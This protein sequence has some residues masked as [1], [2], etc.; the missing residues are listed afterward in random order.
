MSDNIKK[1]TLLQLA[2]I[3]TVYKD[4]DPITR[5]VN[6]CSCGRLIHIDFPE[7]CFAYY[8]HFIE[9][10][11]KRNLILLP[12]NAHAQCVMCNMHTTEEVRKNYHNYMKYRYGDDIKNKL[13][14]YDKII[15]DSEWKDFYI[16]QLLKLSNKFPELISSVLV[17]EDTGELIESTDVIENSIEK[18]FNTYSKT[19]KEDLDRLCKIL[20]TKNIE[21]ERM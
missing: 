19:Y 6:C 2:A 14:N 11:I 20:D 10:S 5:T 15:S 7:D 13:M 9:R 21:W 12:E 3:Y 4:L 16:K 1:Y 17:N 18:Q 8:G